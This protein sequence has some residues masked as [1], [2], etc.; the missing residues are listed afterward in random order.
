MSF[1][2]LEW[3]DKERKMTIIQA[4]ESLKALDSSVE[5]VSEKQSYPPFETDGDTFQYWVYAEDWADF[6][7][8]SWDH[9]LESV[10][11]RLNVHV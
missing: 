5:S 3:D 4:F 8:T 10:K 7:Y 1:S 2:S 6:S 11:R 9:L